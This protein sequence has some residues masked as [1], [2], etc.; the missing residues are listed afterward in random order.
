MRRDFDVLVSDV[1]GCDWSIVFGR[2][3]DRPFKNQR[4]PTAGETESRDSPQAVQGQ[5]TRDRKHG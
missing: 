2:V 5:H 1:E 3:F 4:V